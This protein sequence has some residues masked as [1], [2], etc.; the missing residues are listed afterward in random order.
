MSA[1]FGQCIYG[2]KYGDLKVCAFNLASCD[3]RKKLF[4]INVKKFN[5]LLLNF[6][7]KLSFI[8]RAKNL[9]RNAENLKQNACFYLFPLHF[10]T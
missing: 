6:L 7:S 5:R 10:T 4:N 1:A 3:A 9:M 2:V 8:V